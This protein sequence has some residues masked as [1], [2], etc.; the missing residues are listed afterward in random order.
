MRITTFLFALIA[1]F[2]AWRFFCWGAHGGAALLGSIL[3]ILACLL[4]WLPW[5]WACERQQERE[6]RRTLAAIRNHDGR[7]I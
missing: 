4:A 2:F 6:R 5:L 3:A 7:T 1:S